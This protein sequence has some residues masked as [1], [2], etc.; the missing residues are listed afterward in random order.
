MNQDYRPVSNSEPCASCGATDGWCR[1]THDGMV[2]FCEKQSGGDDWVE[3]QDKNQK[4]FWFRSHR[5]K[6]ADPFRPT[7]SPRAEPHDEPTRDRVYR[8]LLELL[9]LSEH[10]RIL[11]TERGLTGEQ[12]DAA[13]YRTLAIQGRKGLA[14]KLVELFGEDVVSGIPGLHHQSRDGKTWWTLGGAAGILIPCRDLEGKIA[15]IKVRADDVQ[16]S[17]PGEKKRPRYTYVSSSKKGGSGPGNQ[18]HHPIISRPDAAYAG[19]EGLNSGQPDAASRKQHAGLGTPG[20]ESDAAS[21][22]QHAGLDEALASTADAPKGSRP[23]GKREQE[24]TTTTTGNI[25]NVD[26][27]S[28]SQIRITEGELKADLATVLSGI[29]TLSVPGASNWKCAL[30]MLKAL[31]PQR[32]I[33]AFDADYRTNRYVF[34]ALQQAASELKKLNAEVLVETWTGEKGI[35]DQLR[36]G[37]TTTLVD[38]SQIQMDQPGEQRELPEIVCNDR[39]LPDVTK[40]SL[41]ALRLANDPPVLFVKGERVVRIRPA[42]DDPTTCLEVVG[43]N[44]MR[45]HLAR[46][47]RWK[48]VTYTRKGCNEE[49]C[50]PPMDVVRDVLHL[51]ELPFP[52]LERLVTSP[53]YLKDGT[54]LNEPGYHAKQRIYFHG[55]AGNNVPSKP[56][57]EQVDAA[58]HLLLGTLLAEFPFVDLADKTHAVGALLLP[59]VRSLIDGPTPLHLIQAPSAGTGKSLLGDVLCIPSMGSEALTITASREGDE[60]RKTLTATLE[61]SPTWIM[62]DN[63]AARLDSPDLS[64]ATTQSHW[65]DRRLGGSSLARIKVTSCWMATA[66]NP[67]MSDEVCR[68]TVPIFLDARTDE[69]WE[70]DNFSISDLKTW[71]KTHRGELV[72]AALTLVQHWICLG[73]PLSKKTMGSYER[74][75]AIMGG[76]LEACGLDGF[77][78][79]QQKLYSRTADQMAEWRAFLHTWWLKWRGEE[80]ALGDL[81]ELVEREDLLLTVVRGKDARGRKT[82]LG[83]ALKKQEGRII[84]GYRVAA[85]GKDRNH[86]TIWKLFSEDTAPET[87]VSDEDLPDLSSIALDML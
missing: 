86:S 30:P 85:A 2:E 36:A 77:L 24:P 79:N 49:A 22:K 25:P 16:P 62:I 70:R 26:K 19:R 47:A 51:P 11:L 54:L 41:E 80:K 57:Q 68:R 14:G 6:P 69:P 29:L 52:P 43:E 63:I 32:V 48:K 84:G 3:D 7:R 13:Q 75:A 17:K 9:T 34:G 42:S 20:D 21:Q 35:D 5:P 56:T 8:K 55:Q 50:Y 33:L 58:K 81:H 67:H 76:I 83:M 82:S 59:F 71:A 46:A 65:T 78:T 4:P 60:W 87:V 27:R 38:P 72:A 44:A 28:L 39:D 1:R 23:R 37:G 53:T 66:N 61:L 10:H 18:A 15:A 74:Y 12:I 73:K 31:K 40:E 45:G 64:S